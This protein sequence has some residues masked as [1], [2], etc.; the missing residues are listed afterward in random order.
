[1]LAW[2][3]CSGYA[4]TQ[5][6]SILN[7][8]QPELTSSS[9]CQYRPD[10]DHRGLSGHGSSLTRAQVPAGGPAWNLPVTGFST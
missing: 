10:T 8:N 7:Y 6:D 3:E 4:V 5:C 2:T 1:M 9:Y